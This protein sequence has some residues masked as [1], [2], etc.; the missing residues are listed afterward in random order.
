MIILTL[1]LGCFYIVNSNSIDASNKAMEGATVALNVDGTIAKHHENHTN[2]VA[3][4]DSVD[5]QQDKRFCVAN[6]I[7]DVSALNTIQQLVM[8]MRICL[9]KLENIIAPEDKLFEL[10][11][12]VYESMS[13]SSR[14]FHDVQH[15]LDKADGG[16]DIQKLAAFFHDCIYYSVDGGLSDVQKQ[17]LSDVFIESDE[18]IIL[19]SVDTFEKNIELVTDIF[20][21]KAGEKLNPYKGLNEY[22]SATLALRSLASLLSRRHLAEIAVCIEATIPFREGHPMDELYERLEKVNTK[23]NLNMS[24][25]ELEVAIKRATAFANKDVNNFSS[26]NRVIFLSSTWDLLLESNANLRNKQVFNMDEFATALQKVIGFFST[27]KAERI[28]SSFR[29]YPGE[30]IIDE[31][32]QQ[33]RE[34][35]SITL[36]YM[37]CKLLTIAGLAALADQIGVEATVPM[38]L[39]DLPEVNHE[40]SRIDDTSSI[41]KGTSVK[42]LDDRVLT[43]LKEGHGS[44]QE[45]EFNIGKSPCAALLYSD[46]GDR[47]LE[48]SLSHVIESIYYDDDKA[49]LLSLPKSSVIVLAHCYIAITKSHGSVNSVLEKTHIDFGI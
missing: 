21:L 6:K 24:D 29:N 19:A 15:A 40:V 3:T 13:A 30:E 11:C 37:K 48:E 16:D 31:W 49:L 5:Q 33:A 2:M 1:V 41:G 8:E 46:L 17:I 32:T 42:E 26:T 36:V 44:E 10:A 39:G 7:D 38:F 9:S 28:F 35:I 14:I 4:T 25:T 34:N 47:G 22:L 23:Y 20:G 27:L 45:I 43:L 18:G 12:I